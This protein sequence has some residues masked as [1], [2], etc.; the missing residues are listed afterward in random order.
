MTGTAD[1]TVK[2]NAHIVALAD[3]ILIV[4]VEKSG[5]TEALYKEAFA[6]MT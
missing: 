6:D 2:H 1:F 5:K 4:D 3:R